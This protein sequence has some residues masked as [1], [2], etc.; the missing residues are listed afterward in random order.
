MVSDGDFFFY[1]H[2]QNFK[3]TSI[4]K[5]IPGKGKIRNIY[6]SKQQMIVSFLVAAQ[7][8]KQ[9]GIAVLSYYPEKS[10]FSF[11]LYAL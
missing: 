10:K 11:F 6:L 7:T 1:L 4:H 5:G 9:Q 3:N 8:L 2:S